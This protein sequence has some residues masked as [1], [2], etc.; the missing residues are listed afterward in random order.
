M[1]HT[2]DP[3]ERYTLWG[4]PL[5]VYTAKVRSYL[6]K[7]RIP[8]R[9]L[10]PSHPDFNSRI[11]PALG[12]FVIPVLETPTRRVTPCRKPWSRCCRSSSGTGARR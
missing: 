10:F 3:A 8:Y 1:T 9:E 5:S 4:G 11:I 7:K 2:I 12:F 6:I